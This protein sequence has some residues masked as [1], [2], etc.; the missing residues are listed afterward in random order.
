[1]AYLWLNYGLGTWETTS[2]LTFTWEGQ[3][4]ANLD[5]SRTSMNRILNYIIW[6]AIAG[7]VFGM[8][9]L[10]L[11]RFAGDIPGLSAYL[12]GDTG[13]EFNLSEF[14][15]ADAFAKA[16]PAVVSINS[17]TEVNRYLG[18]QR[19]NPFQ[20]RPLFASDESTS[21]GSGVI[22][23]PEGYIITS[24]HIF[25]LPDPELTP[26]R[27]DPLPTVIV[28]LYDG[29]NV[30]ANVLA[31][32]EANDLTLLKIDETNLA[33]LSQ[34][35][36]YTLDAGDIVLAIGN[37]RNIGQS[38]TLGII[39]ALLSTG[40]SY[41]IQTDAAINPGNSGGALVDINGRLVGINSTI[42][43]ES[44][45]SEGISF[46]IPA[47]K[48]VGLM[49]AYIEQGP[50]GFM[51]VGGRFVNSGFSRLM[52]DA[53]AAG[54]WVERVSKNGPADKAGL[55]V[56]DI[57]LSLEGINITDDLTAMQ[58]IQ[59][60]NNMRPGETVVATINREGEILTLP[61][62]LGVGEAVLWLSEED[63]SLDPDPF[64]NGLL[65]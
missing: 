24:F 50:G 17:T 57:I 8:V 56:N 30:E 42:V 11:P 9:L 51:G 25:E 35:D 19:V 43:S 3:P 40:D 26:N 1:M 36:E 46:A 60:T 53:T 41:V 64:R 47:S 59:T 6:P 54:L 22:I 63:Q 52:L 23:S 21:L 15:F 44:G 61:I 28:T 32:D 29:R 20:S 34:A 38:I 16:A 33:Y 55:R 62:I 39:S 45:G 13:Q 7:L 49:Q 5:D 58:A 4:S 14:T 31:V 12:P 48:A 2:R 27:N 65:R 37:P 10:Q 18:V